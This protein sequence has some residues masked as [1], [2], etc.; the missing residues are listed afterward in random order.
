MA[1]ARPGGHHQTASPMGPTRADRRVTRRSVS[2]PSG[3]PGRATSISTTP[4][5]AANARSSSMRRIAPRSGTD[6]AASP[7]VHAI[8]ETDEPCR[9]AMEMRPPAPRVSSSGWG[10]ND[11]DPARRQ[12]ERRP[13]DQVGAPLL[14]SGSRI[15]RT[16]EPAGSGADD[17]HRHAQCR[18]SARCSNR[19]SGSGDT[20]GR[21]G[22]MPRVARRS[23][24]TPIGLVVAVRLLDE[25]APWPRRARPPATTPSYSTGSVMWIVRSTA[26]PPLELAEVRTDGDDLDA[27]RVG[28][29]APAATRPAWW[30]RRRP[31]PRPSGRSTRSGLADVHRQ[32]TARACRGSN[33]VTRRARRCRGGPPPASARSASTWARLATIRARIP[34]L[35][36]LASSKLNAPTM[37]SCSTAVSDR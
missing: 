5:K 20:P 27:E 18:C 22:S 28:G 7:S 33:G 34:G 1:V 10:D 35:T 37:C 26:T 15:F 29:G 19:S 25:D 21:S 32:R 12:I 6:D 4:V 16:D 17:R 14:F 9:A 3:R 30:W 13:V 31:G 23:S 36:H 11:D 2:S 8:T 24:D